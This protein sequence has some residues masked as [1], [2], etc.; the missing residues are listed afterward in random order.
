VGKLHE[1]EPNIERLLEALLELMGWQ[2]E[3]VQAALR[4]AKQQSAGGRRCT[5]GKAARRK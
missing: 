2:A 3:L 1:T 4:Q 5:K